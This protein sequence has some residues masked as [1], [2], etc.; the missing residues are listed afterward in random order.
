[1]RSFV[2]TAA[3]MA[4]SGAAAAQTQPAA[5]DPAGA[6]RGVAQIA[7]P[8]G[9]DTAMDQIS[10]GGRRVTASGQLS[11][12]RGLRAGPQLNRGGRTA[13]APASLSTPA[14]GRRP[15]AAVP[16]GGADRCDPG[17]RPPSRPAPDCARVLEARSAEFERAEAPLSPEQRLLA[18]RRARTSALADG[19]AVARRAASGAIEDDDLASQAVAA[20]VLAASKDEK[21]EDPAG[22]A[23]P[24]DIPAALLELI[25]GGGSLGA[26]VVVNPPPR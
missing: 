4:C 20:S 9:Q 6:A 23:A 22:S 2:L 10:P 1:M 3:L 13:E 17:V 21:E 19:R 14:Q 15:T 16:I 11:A 7:A 12:E 18:E 8:R 5:V 25:T 24:T 26:G